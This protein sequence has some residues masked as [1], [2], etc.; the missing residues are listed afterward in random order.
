MTFWYFSFAKKS[1]DRFFTFKCCFIF[2]SIHT[3]E[4]KRLLSKRFLVPTSNNIRFR[5]PGVRNTR[6]N[7]R[8]D[9]EKFA[10]TPK[11]HV[12]P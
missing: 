4:Q 2:Q 10:S 8:I 6:M 1:F 7:D 5:P 3:N 11:A 12:R 9:S